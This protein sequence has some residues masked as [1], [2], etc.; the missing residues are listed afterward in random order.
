MGNM[1]SSQTKITVSTNA[2]STT[3]TSQ[4]ESIDLIQSGN[5]NH[6][7]L[8]YESPVDSGSSEEVQALKGIVE[9]QN[10]LIAVYQKRRKK[11]D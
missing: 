6:V 8:H 5:N 11:S 2:K 9:H 10:D 7:I 4:D 3:T 1:Y